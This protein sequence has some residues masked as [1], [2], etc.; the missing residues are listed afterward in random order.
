MADKDDA[1]PQVVKEDETLAEDDSPRRLIWA[2]P[3]RMKVKLPSMIVVMRLICRM[4]VTKHGIGEAFKDIS[5][6]EVRPNILD[7]LVKALA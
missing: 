3:L 7:C 6:I 4:L 2:G 5:S 1:C